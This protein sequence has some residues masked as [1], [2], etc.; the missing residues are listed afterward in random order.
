MT[1]GSWQPDFW[2]SGGV[3]DDGVGSVNPIGRSIR[4]YPSILFR[5]GVRRQAL[6]LTKQL[7]FLD[8]K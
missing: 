7:Y 5:N 8:R 6:I 4:C 2:I 3:G 1:A